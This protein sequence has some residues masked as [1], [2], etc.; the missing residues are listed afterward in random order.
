MPTGTGFSLHPQDRGES[1]M[2]TFGHEVTTERP[3]SRHRH[4]VVLNVHD[5]L[6]EREKSP[7]RKAT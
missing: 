6:E 3:L 1:V 4:L 5:T 2:L 7:Q